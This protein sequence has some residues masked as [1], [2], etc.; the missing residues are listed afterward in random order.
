PSTASRSRSGRTRSSGAAA[1]APDQKR[2]GPP[3]APTASRAARADARTR[4]VSPDQRQQLL[5]GGHVL[6]PGNG[7]AARG[8]AEDV[9]VPPVGGRRTGDAEQPVAG[10]VLQ[11]HA[12]AAGE[13]MP[14]GHGPGPAAPTARP[15]RRSGPVRPPAAG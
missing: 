10:Q 11:R 15:G 5:E 6:A 3:S 14:R 13:R 2:A 8:D 4:A 1:A 9:E 12:Q 7:R